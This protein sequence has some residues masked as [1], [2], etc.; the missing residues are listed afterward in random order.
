[1]DTEQLE[2]ELQI[3]DRLMYTAVGS[4]IAL[5]IISFGN[6]MY[7]DQWSGFQNYASGVWQWMQLAITP[8][9]FYLLWNKRWRTLPFH[10]RK[11]TILGFFIASWFT[12]LSLSLIT[13]NYYLIDL[14]FFITGSVALI[15]F[16]YKWISTRKPSQPDE[17][18]P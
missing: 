8:P 13:L 16:G 3:W 7:A 17:M 6:Y 11:N 2:N 18:F 9:G 5:L 15:T 14:G 4:S 1:M 12:F 10:E